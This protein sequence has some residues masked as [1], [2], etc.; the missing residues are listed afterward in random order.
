[1]PFY[2]YKCDCGKAFE[3]FVTMSEMKGEVDC[4]ICGKKAP[5]DYSG[6][7]NIALRDNPRVSRAMG[8]QPSQVDIAMKKWPGSRYDAQGNLLI[9]NRAE[10]LQR[11]KQRGYT[12]F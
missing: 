4:P 8:V 3:I 9:A 6:K 7:C 10:K 1:M 5:R 2:Q 11:M 12:E